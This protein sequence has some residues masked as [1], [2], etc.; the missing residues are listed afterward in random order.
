[1]SLSRRRFVQGSVA[2][3]VL[4]EFGA[5]RASAAKAAEAAAADWASA[6]T[7]T[8]GLAYLN[9]AS[10]GTIPEPVQRA[11]A[12]YLQLCETNPWLYIWSE[13]WEEP[14][15]EVRAQAAG[16]LGGEP[17]RI[18]LTHNTTEAFN[19]LAHGLPLGPGDEVLFSTLNHDGA[20]ICWQIRAPERGFS[21][22]RFEFPLDEVPAMEAS[23]VVARYA[24]AIGPDTRA[25][26][27]PHIDN[28]VGLRHPLKQIAD[29]AHQVGVRWVLVDGAQAAGML[30]LDVA[31]TGVDVYAASA[32]KWVQAPKGLGMA[33]FGESVR[34]ALRP[35]WVTWGQQR[36][37]DTARRFED[38]GTR[39]VPALM[40]LGDA[41][42][43]QAAIDG[44]ARQ[45]HDAALRDYLIER[46][47]AAPGLAW[48]S[49]R[50]PGLSSSILAVD[51]GGRPAGAAAQS[52]FADHGIVVRPFEIDGANFL[53]VSPNLNN[54]LDELDRLITALAA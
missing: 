16:L 46:V 43:F 36:W 49:P 1:M 38:Y 33:Y 25:L 12:R 39:A 26:V 28:M 27:L 18:A 17:D 19:L 35:M 15:S 29:M 9:H 13:P 32:H 31:A 48:R 54:R 22:R 4:A 24:D 21:V 45:R 6:Y 44:G 42:T 5:L 34:D 23:D 53:R 52:L 37:P 8:P 3:A 7:L 50:D 30:A 41:L 40:A 20:S 51:I 47:D 10:V 14:R 11:H 2:A